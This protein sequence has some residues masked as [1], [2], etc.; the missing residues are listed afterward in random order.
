MN[1]T[2]LIVVDIQND[3]FSGGKWELNAVDS[4]AD[5]IFESGAILLCL[6]KR[7][8]QFF[9]KDS[10]GAASVLQ[11]LFWQAASL[12]PILGQ[13]VFFLNTRPS[14]CRLL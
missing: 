10:K 12:G 11:W 9:P 6:A 5:K 2:A 14:M 13:V 3:Y 1:D 8:G 4:A 7:R